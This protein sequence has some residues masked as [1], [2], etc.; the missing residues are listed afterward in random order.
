MTDTREDMRFAD[1]QIANHNDEIEGLY[2]RK[3][4]PAKVYKIERKP[5]EETGKIDT[6]TLK[7]DDR[8]RVEYNDGLIWWLRW[9]CVK[10]TNAIR[11]GS[12]KILAVR[13]VG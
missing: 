10:N 7:D 1:S 12:G 6:A 2:R 8:V 11:M 5:V 4:E 3:M 9:S 13:R